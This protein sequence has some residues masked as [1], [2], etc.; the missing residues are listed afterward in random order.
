[1]NTTK[2]V[3]LDNAAT[4]PLDDQVIAAMTDAMKN[5]GNPSASHCTGRAAKALLETSRRT[6]AKLINAERR[7]IVFTSGGTEADNMAI[8]CAVKDLGIKSIITSPIEH[9]AVLETSQEM[10]QSGLASLHLVHVD[11]TGT[12][13]YAHLEE[14]AQTN[15]NSLISLMHANNEIGTLL[16]YRE[17]SRI[18]KENNCLFH[19]DTVQT[20]GHYSFDVEEFGA[21]FLTC[22]AHKLNGPKGIGFLYTNKKLNIK[23]MIT[24]GGQESN[25]RAGTENM[26]GIAGL[27]K[28]LEIAFTNVKQEQD[29]IYGIKT[30]MMEQLAIHI[31]DIEFNGRTTFEDGLY[32]VLSCSLP[33][34]KNNDLILF[35]LDIE[36]VCCSGGSACNSGAAKGS[37]VLEAIN[38]PV[39]RKAIRFSFGRFT[40][41]YDINHA[42]KALSKVLSQETVQA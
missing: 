42:V 34:Q 1:M 21:D 9:K 25:H 22:S 13:D 31:P 23:S 36:G 28:A 7:E 14:L 39:D 20:M 27:T 15:P 24:G 4:T 5:Y 17:V 37:H 11:E 16:D 6:I 18:A 41:K 12:V 8:R 35:Q 10:E 30:Y 32:T 3:Y 26:L 33:P 29:H 40:S 19:S 38:H 2:R